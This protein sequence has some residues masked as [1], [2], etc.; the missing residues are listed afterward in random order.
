[1]GVPPPRLNSSTWRTKSPITL[2]ICLIIALAR[3]LVAIAP[4]ATKKAGANGPEPT[5]AEWRG[6]LVAHVRASHGYDCPIEF[7]EPVGRH[8]WCGNEDK[9]EKRL[10]EC[11]P[12][13]SKI[14]T[15]N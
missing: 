5:S 8:S 4:R 11:R 14:N 7:S 13:G 10:S 12:P 2:S 3:I 6:I 15:G 1:M 9:G